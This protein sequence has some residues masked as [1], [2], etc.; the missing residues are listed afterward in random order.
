MKN[1]I[2]RSGF[3]M[4]MALML[5]LGIVMARG[6][7]KDY[8]LS[9]DN[10]REFYSY[11]FIHQIDQIPPDILR[12]HSATIKKV[13]EIIRKN[14]EE[15]TITSEANDF[16]LDYYYRN[17]A[18][19]VYPYIQ[20]ESLKKEVKSLM[21]DIVKKLVNSEALE[22]HNQDTYGD[23]LPEP[24]TENGITSEKLMHISLKGSGYNV[25]KAVEYAKKW[26]QPGS[27]V[28]NPAYQKY[29][30]DCTNFVSQ[31]LH[32]SAAGGI[33]YIHNDN[34]G[35]D[36]NDVSNWY[37]ALGS[38]YNG[39]SWTWGGAENLYNHLKNYSTNVRRLYN[40]ND[41]QVGDVVSWDIYNDGKFNI[42]HSTVV[43]K[44]TGTGSSGLYFTYHSNEREDEPFKTL[45]DAGYVGYAW[46]INH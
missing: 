9:L 17:I 7:F 31:V 8:S 41:V 5:P 3:F 29:A 43:T 23:Q 40:W 24:T 14:N 28:R 44:K 20:D 16:D 2:L 26:T 38:G 42:N 10:L 30:N 18:L 45:S 4:I 35:W 39:P 36:Y 6:T 1:R 33:S 37:H 27:I 22:K 21:E 46:A 32:D 19:G 34:W 25:S 15:G 13:D 12:N 11:Q